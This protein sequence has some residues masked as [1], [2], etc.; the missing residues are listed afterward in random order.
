MERCPTCNLQYKRNN[1]Y[2]HELV[3]THLSAIDQC[4]CQQCKTRIN[5][6]DKDSIYNQMNVKILKESGIVMYVKKL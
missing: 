4:Y 3:N 6:A 5:L 2:N 1:K